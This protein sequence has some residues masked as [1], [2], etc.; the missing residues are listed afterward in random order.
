MEFALS[1]ANFVYFY[2]EN[3]VLFWTQMNTD[4]QEF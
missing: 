4:Y 3:L 2:I 1:E